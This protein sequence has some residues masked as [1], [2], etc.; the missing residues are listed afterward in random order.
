[1][2]AQKRREVRKLGIRRDGTP[3]RQIGVK[4]HEDMGRF[5][6]RRAAAEDADLSD[7]VRQAADLYRDLYEQLGDDWHEAK[8]RAGIADQSLGATLASIIKTV[9]E[10]ERKP[11]K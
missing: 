2:A 6:E 3:K 9:F 5:F 11:K 4:F 8:K 10:A 1:M 7:I